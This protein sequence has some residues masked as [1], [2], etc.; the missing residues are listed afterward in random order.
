LHRKRSVGILEQTGTRVCG[1]IPI[2]KSAL[3]VT[4][5]AHPLKGDHSAQ[6]LSVPCV[7]WNLIENHSIFFFKIC[8]SNIS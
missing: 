1:M 5:A 2:V 8:N 3:L 4:A 7:P 6:H